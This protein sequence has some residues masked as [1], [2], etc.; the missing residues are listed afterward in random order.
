MR[1][2]MK[3]CSPR[4]KMENKY[5]PCGVKKKEKKI[6]P[7]LCVEETGHPGEILRI[8]HINLF[9]RKFDSEP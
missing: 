2:K 5:L 7:S 8:W 3:I 1:V 4:K 6:P 9:Q